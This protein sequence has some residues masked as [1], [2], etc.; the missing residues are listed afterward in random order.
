MSWILDEVRNEILLNQNAITTL[1]NDGRT[2]VAY[3]EMNRIASNVGAKHRVRVLLNFPVKNEIFNLNSMTTKGVSIIA[4]ASVKQFRT[5]SE[6]QVRRELLKQ[7]PNA[8]IS[9]AR[10]GHEGFHADFELGRL[11]VLPSGVHVWCDVD[12]RVREFLDWL[13]PNA[14]GIASHQ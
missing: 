14:Y 13:F 12:S 1:L 9:P 4:D 11:T 6:D 8:S 5:C 7:I 10:F 2:F 3:E